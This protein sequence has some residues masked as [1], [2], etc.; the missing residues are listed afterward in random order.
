MGGGLGNSISNSSRAAGTPTRSPYWEVRNLGV[1]ERSARGEAGSVSRQTQA[2]GSRRLSGSSRPG[3]DGSVCPGH[4]TE[5]PAG[6][7]QKADHGGRA[8]LRTESTA[9]RKR[10]GLPIEVLQSTI[11][12]LTTA[13]PRVP[14]CGV[15]DY[16]I[17]QF[18][19]CRARPDGSSKPDACH[20]FTVKPL[21][22]PLNRGRHD[23]CIA[24]CALDNE[25]LCLH[26]QHQ[27]RQS[28]QPMR[29]T[30]VCRTDARAHG[31]A[32]SFNRLSLVL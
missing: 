25:T 7:R 4:P 20:R 18:E 9:H 2:T 14:Q 32:G 5:A 30:I 15:V 22:Y 28:G 8:I 6:N 17:A 31:R 11:Q 24:E 21:S 10:Q 13:Q 3:S 23:Y 19:L 12:A 16:N 27:R 29:S 1:G 26:R